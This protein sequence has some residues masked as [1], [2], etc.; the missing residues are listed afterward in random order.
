MFVTSE[1]EEL[2]IEIFLPYRPVIGPLEQYT[3][4]EI[5]NKIEAS[6]E[7]LSNPA[8]VLSINKSS[9][10]F[11]INGEADYQ[12]FDGFNKDETNETEDIM[13]EPPLTPGEDNLPEE[14]LSETDSEDN[15]TGLDQI[16]EDGTEPDAQAVP[17]EFIADSFNFVMFYE[18]RCKSFQG[19]KDIKFKFFE[20]YPEVTG[21]VINGIINGITVPKF[22]QE[23]E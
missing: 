18:Y 12:S 5:V 16:P 17:N 20:N 14:D 15:V 22:R 11:L 3:E 8:S 19:I 2:Y 23:K 21:I 7:K 13:K 1:K 9:V 6:I 4:D 10:C